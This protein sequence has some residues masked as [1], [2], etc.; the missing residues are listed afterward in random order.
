MNLKILIQL[1]G[2]VNNTPG[3]METNQD[4]SLFLEQPIKVEAKAAAVAVPQS[5][6]RC[7]DDTTMQQTK[8]PCQT[9]Q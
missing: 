1:L 2:L 8:R 6:L 4:T 9:S 3:K 7:R 5:K